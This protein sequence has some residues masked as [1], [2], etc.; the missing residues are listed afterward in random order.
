VKGIE[1]MSDIDSRLARA[2]D[3]KSLAEI[4]TLYQQWA[5]DYDRDTLEHLG[6]VGPKELVNTFVKHFISRDERI[7][8]IGCGTGLVG[9]ELHR[10]GFRHFDG[11]DISEEMLAEAEKKGI[12]NT[13]IQGDLT[14]PLG[15]LTDF[16]GAVV[17][18]GVFTCG[19]LGPYLLDEI[20]RVVRPGGIVCVS[21]HEDVYES[22]GY[23]EKINALVESSKCVV[24]E[25]NQADYL[26]K[27]GLHAHIC[28]LRV[29]IA[30]ADN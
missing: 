5:P 22:E 10:A 13:L 20:I 16:Y 8:D 30:T 2:Y 29:I 18:A 25:N 11:F 3:V 26:L 23:L 4:K 12:Y 7:L 6:Y 28:V 15:I 9:E 27:E 1:I 14:Q 17:S 21:I 24:S 19:H